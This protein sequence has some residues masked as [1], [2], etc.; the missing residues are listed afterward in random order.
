MPFVAAF[1][2]NLFSLGLVDQVYA[3]NKKEKSVSQEEQF[4]YWRT[5][6]GLPNRFNN[7]LQ[8]FTTFEANEW[9]KEVMRRAK[10]LK[11]E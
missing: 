9:N 1:Q 5:T 7:G 6:G 10:I 8:R 2:L 3:M 4:N 11:L